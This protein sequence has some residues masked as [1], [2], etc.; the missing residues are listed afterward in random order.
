MPRAL[1]FCCVPGC[2]SGSRVPGHFIPKKSIAEKWVKAIKNPKLYGLTIDQLKRYRVCHK[3]FLEECVLPDYASRRLREGTIPT[4]NLPI[5]ENKIIINEVSISEENKFNT[6]EKAEGNKINLLG[7]IKLEEN[8]KDIPLNISLNNL[9]FDEQL[10]QLLIEKPSL[11]NETAP[12][13]SSI[14]TEKLNQKITM[15]KIQNNKLEKKIASYEHKW[16]N[17]E[18]LLAEAA[19]LRR[20]NYYLEKRIVAYENKFKNKENF[21]AVEYDFLK[22]SEDQFSNQ[23]YANLK[24]RKKTLVSAGLDKLVVKYLKEQCKQMTKNETL[25]SLSWNRMSLLPHIQYD[26]ETDTIIGFEN[27]GNLRTSKFADHSLTFMLRG[28]SKDWEIP[29]GYYLCQSKTRPLRLIRCITEII[30]TV[31]IAGFTVLC[32]VCN[33]SRINVK[34][35][36][37]LLQD[38]RVQCLEEGQNSCKGCFQINGQNIIPLYNPAHLLIEIRNNLLHKDV[39]L[40]WPVGVNTERH[41]GSW[42][43]IELAYYIDRNLVCVLRPI[44]H[45]LTDCHVKKKRINRAKLKYASQ[46]FSGTVAAFIV[47]LI[48]MGHINTKTGKL[49]MPKAEAIITAKFLALFND[50]FDSVSGFTSKSNTPLRAAVT[51]HSNHLKFWTEAEEKLNSIRF[52]CKI[53]KKEE[54]VPVISQWIQTI[55]GFKNLWK[56][57]RQKKIYQ[58][59]PKKLDQQ[60]LNKFLSKIKSQNKQREYMTCYHYQLS[61]QTLL[62]KELQITEEVEHILS[63]KNVAVLQ[64]LKEFKIFATCN[65]CC[66][67][68]KKARYFEDLE[69]MANKTMQK[70]IYS[71]CFKKHIGCK[72]SLMLKSILNFS[73]FTCQEHAEE[74]Q[75]KLIKILIKNFLSDWCEK[76]NKILSRWGTRWADTMLIQEARTSKLNNM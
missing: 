63:N 74:L 55:R 40:N 61:F 39:R 62:V 5:G 43:I 49:Y 58:F 6:V 46:V 14:Y 9:V 52:I 75:Y 33:P 28:I 41:V 54:Q 30:K 25:C 18:I 34:C 3:H 47:F 64:A 50:L 23:Q 32:T 17:T 7:T 60:P 1:Y 37:S 76:M 11:N 35:I 51:R 36:E 57:L 67:T 16:K 65:N 19:K 2:N 56:I 12:T 59:L 70:K 31:Q 4:L 15:L 29:L 68:L 38:A 69:L 13:M 22:I 45:K 26:M 42:N 21:T 10:N 44:M 48:N 24:V 8:N 27:L 20:D 66:E 72:L 53:S 73:G 71:V